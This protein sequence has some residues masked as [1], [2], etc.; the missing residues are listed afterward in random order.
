MLDISGEESF[1]PLIRS[2]TIVAAYY[3]VEF[4]QRV[5][6]SQKTYTKKSYKQY[7][8]MSDNEELDNEAAGRGG[9]DFEDFDYGES[10]VEEPDLMIRVEIAT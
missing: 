5:I 6:D 1:G 10:G 4:L 8:E 3:D 7:N 9:F 2:L